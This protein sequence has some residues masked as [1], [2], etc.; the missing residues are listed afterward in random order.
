MAVMMRKHFVE[1]ANIVGITE[2]QNPDMRRE[3]VDSLRVNMII[4]CKKFNPQFDAQTFHA[5]CDKT[6]DNA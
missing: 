2:R 3:G 1:L 4:F 5:A 6:R